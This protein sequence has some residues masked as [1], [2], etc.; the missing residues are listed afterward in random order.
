M[1][2][3]FRLLLAVYPRDA[4]RRYGA[5]ITETVVERVNRSRRGRLR[6]VAREVSGLFLAGLRLRLEPLRYARRSKKPRTR[7]GGSAMDSFL[8]DIRIAARGLLKRPAFSGIAVLAMTLGV[9]ASVAIYSVFHAVLL[10]PLPF[11]EPDRLVALWEKNSERGWYK[12]QAAAANFLDW[13]EESRSFSGMA[14][15]NSWLDELALMVEGEPTQVRANRVTGSFFDVLGVPPLQGGVFDERHTWAGTERAAVLSQHL[16]ARQF[17]SDP[18]VVGRSIELDGEPYRVLGVMPDTFRF[19]YRDADVWLSMAWEPEYRSEAR[20]RR[21]HSI[22]V[23]GRLRSGVGLDEAEAEIAGIM[24]RLEQ[25]YPETNR[26]M[27][28]GMTGLHEWVVGDTRR[29]VQVLMAAVLFLLLIAC[30][31]VANMM[32]AREAGRVEERRIR[33]ALGASRLRLLLPGLADGLILGV[34]SGGLG[35]LLG[36]AIL[37]PILAMSP[38]KLP[39]I[40]EV[41]VSSSAVGFAFGVG[42][43]GALLAGILSAARVAFSERSQGL[44]L[45]PRGASSSRGSRRA[46]ALLVAL[47]VALTLPL[48]VGAGLM[49]QTLWRLTRVEPGFDRRN[50][51]AA[52]ISLPVIRYEEPERMASFIETFVKSVS[53][54]PGVETAAASGGLPFKENGWS[55][56]F[57]AEGWGPDRFG[58]DVRHDEATPGLFTTMRVPLLRGR[59]FEWSDRRGAPWVAIVNQALADKYFPGEE[60]VGKRI[61]FDRVPGSESIWR[62]IVGVVGNVRDETLATE[63]DPTIYAAMLQEEDIGFHLLVRSHGNPEPLTTE[64]RSRL[65]ALDP[66]IPLY[67][68]TTLDAMVSSSVSRERFLLVL[69]AAAA[70]VALAL[71]TVGIGGVVS[72]S[73]AH[74]VREIGIRMAL[75][76]EGRSVVGL[77]VREG[78][79]PVVAGIAVGAAAAAILARAMSGLLYDVEPLDP[80]TFLAVAAIMT[81]AALVACFVPARTAAGVDAARTL[82]SD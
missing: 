29:P 13:K 61:V 75:G 54:I 53:A 81:L 36:G 33:R 56:D 32:L 9:G 62:E 44:A 18:S 52:R 47:E 6:L 39:R 79:R 7:R 41:A 16:W 31:N 2:R 45:A 34:L 12:V 25:R 20:F 22:Y 38:E 24:S 65:S 17:G 4:R 40:D 70:F 71:A 55:S 82:R 63:E 43:V 66:A 3:I 42:V 51:L 50:V 5:E 28:S 59:E 35:V 14:A 73:T 11:A 60:P 80:E 76:A 49:I 37:R 58:I 74:R 1:N 46:S 67:D 10:R 72:Q 19:P 21:A 30:I 64:V 77:V 26:L 57:T 23:V 48:V 8:H 78:M 15:Y 69:L 68:V 27:Q